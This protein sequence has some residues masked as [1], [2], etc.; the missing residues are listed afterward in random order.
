MAALI[1]AA[2]AYFAAE[3]VEPGVIRHIEGN[4]ISFGE[5]D[6][7]R[8]DRVRAITQALR[9]VRDCVAVLTLRAD[10]YP[11]L[12]QSDLWPVAEAVVREN[13]PVSFKR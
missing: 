11:E 4:R 10:F 3:M 6:G 8:S 5:P 7:T 12:M 1:L 9:G 2:L 13:E